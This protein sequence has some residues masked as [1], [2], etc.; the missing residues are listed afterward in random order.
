MFNFQNFVKVIL[1]LFCHRCCYWRHPLQLSL[2]YKDFLI[3]FFFIW[4]CLTT[5]KSESKLQFQPLEING[6]KKIY[7]KL[8]VFITCPLVLYRFVS[9]NAKLKH[10]NAV[11][12]S[13]LN[14]WTMN[15]NNLYMILFSS[16]LKMPTHIDNVC[17]W[18]KLPELKYEL[19]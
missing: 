17:F 11:S 14:S 4:K 7:N 15:Y 19:I 3:M 1:L 5:W 18:V 12:Y 2:N 13:S 8:L 10:V 6:K 16:Y 9:R